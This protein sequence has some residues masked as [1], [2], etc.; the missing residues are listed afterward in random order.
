[1]LKKFALSSK[2]FPN[3][4]PAY[5][6]SCLSAPDASDSVLDAEGLEE[7]LIHAKNH[8]TIKATEVRTGPSA[9]LIHATNLLTTTPTETRAGTP[10]HLIH[11]TNLPYINDTLDH[12]LTVLDTDISPWTN[13]AGWIQ[14]NTRYICGIVKGVAS[15]IHNDEIEFAIFS[16]AMP[17]QVSWTLSWASNT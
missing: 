14:A 2:P 10:A 13:P 6:P 4:A 9:H 1:M 8:P 3:S 5:L 15:I 11:T 7:T 17:Y 16:G 12:A